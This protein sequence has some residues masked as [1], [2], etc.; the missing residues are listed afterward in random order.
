M[1]QLR[2]FFG[3]AWAKFIEV[4]V[5][6]ADVGKKLGGKVEQNIARASSRTLVQFA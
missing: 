4:N 5:P 1:A 2:P 3:A 6:V